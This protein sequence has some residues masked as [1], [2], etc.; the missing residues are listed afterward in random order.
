MFQLWLL[1]M[2]IPE[3]IQVSNFIVYY[4]SQHHLK[5][6]K[7]SRHPCALLH[8]NFLPNHEYNY[9]ASLVKI[10]IMRKWSAAHINVI[11]FLSFYCI[12]GSL[13]LVILTNKFAAYIGS[14]EMLKK[15][16]L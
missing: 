5:T 16:A 7:L 12:V 10:D 14:S 3:K 9:N 1:H 15:C 11:T 6:T 8:P 13:P 2:V 4:F